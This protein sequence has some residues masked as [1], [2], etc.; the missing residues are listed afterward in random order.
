MIDLYYWPTPNGRKISIMLEECELEFF[1][2]EKEL[3]LDLV[4]VDLASGE[5]FRAEFREINPDCVVPVLELD[6]GSHL[7]E[8]IAIC[9]Y[10]LHGR[11][12]FDRVE[13][14]TQ[15]FEVIEIVTQSSIRHHPRK[16]YWSR[17]PVSPRVSRN[18]PEQSDAGHC[19][20]R[21]SH[22]G[23]RTETGINVIEPFVD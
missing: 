11:P 5:Q 6:D 21:L 14:P 23:Q 4:A 3:D 1:V 13:P 7:S 19:R 22:I 9:H 8:V 2:A 18:Q 15:V 17:G 16:R 20:S 12:A 10:L